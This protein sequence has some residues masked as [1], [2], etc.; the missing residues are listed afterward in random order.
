MRRKWVKAKPK[1]TKKFRINKQIC[2]SEVFLIDQDGE[3]VGNIATSKALEMAREFGM[4]L[5]EVNPKVSPPVAKIVDFGQL[6]YEQEK[7]A[8]KQKAQQKKIH[9][10][11]IRLSVRISSHDFGF[12]LNNA[13]KFLAKGDKVK[14]SLTL[15][16]RERQHPQ[17]GIETIKNFVDELKSDEALNIEEEQGLTKQ[18]GRFTMIVVN[19][20]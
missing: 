8:Q 16:G 6:K 18:G 2:V 7:K 20:I 15:K 19:K 17:K 4:D 9:T 3:N 12:R 14:I 10:K 13:R 11:E 1:L 5:V